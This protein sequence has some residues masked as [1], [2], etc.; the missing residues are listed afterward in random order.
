MDQLLTKSSL[1]P[2]SA[3]LVELMQAINYGRIED[4]VIRDGQPVFEPAPHI[5]QK[6]KIGADNGPRPEAGY[7]DFRLKGGV[8]E[9]LELFARLKDGEIRTIEIRCGLPVSAELEWFSGQL[10]V[11][12]PSPQSR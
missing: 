12:G 7:I 1:T 8:I 2:E 10:Y 9:L 6:V 11:P 3:H 4:L 5:I